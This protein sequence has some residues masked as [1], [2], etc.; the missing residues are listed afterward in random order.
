MIGRVIGLLRGSSSS[1]CVRC[2]PGCVNLQ[3][4]GQADSKCAPSPNRRVT[5]ANTCAQLLASSPTMAQPMH[6]A[7]RRTHGRGASASS[8]WVPASRS[9]DGSRRRRA[10][11]ATLKQW[12]DDRADPEEETNAMGNHMGNHSIRSRR[13]NMG[14]RMGN[15]SI[16]SPTLNIDKTKRE[17]LL[18]AANTLSVG[19]R[20]IEPS[21]FIV[22]GL[23][24]L[25]SCF[26]FFFALEFIRESTCL[27]THTQ[28]SGCMLIATGGAHL[29]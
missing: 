4:G 26:S 27:Y 17:V 25:F 29:A 22:S 16:S 28:K 21:F 9:T 12:N 15:H 7:H 3:N 19:V 8:R 6:A 24:P 11:T 18:R 5:F 1:W 23:L 20:G 2:S 13:R 14:N 10:Q